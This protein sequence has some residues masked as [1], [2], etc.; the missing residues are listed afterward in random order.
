MESQKWLMPPPERET[1]SV[2]LPPMADEL[3]LVSDRIEPKSTLF[4]S[5]PPKDAESAVLSAKEAI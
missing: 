1:A 3:P 5:M 4:A 2:L